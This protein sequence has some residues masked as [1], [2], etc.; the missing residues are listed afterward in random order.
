MELLSS[1][2][3]PEDVGRSGRPASCPAAE[4]C[5]AAAAPR[6]HPR[7]GSVAPTVSP[8]LE[9]N[10]MLKRSAHSWINDPQKHPTV[11]RAEEEMCVFYGKM[12]VFYGNELCSV[13]KASVFMQC[14]LIFTH[15]GETIW[16]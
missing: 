5:D 13:V 8:E 2:V 12:C 4:G 7:L 9:T 1:Y 14:S 15:G 16:Q 10:W 6:F 11:G 3:P